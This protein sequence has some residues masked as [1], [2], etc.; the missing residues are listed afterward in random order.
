MEYLEYIDLS[1]GSRR[2]RFVSLFA[3][4]YKKH[5]EHMPKRVFFR[6][7]WSELLLPHV[8]CHLLRNKGIRKRDCW[9]APLQII[10][11]YKFGTNFHVPN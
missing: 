11:S 1:S 6:G 10:P 2:R 7:D 3:G 9:L 8:S 5:V 4:F